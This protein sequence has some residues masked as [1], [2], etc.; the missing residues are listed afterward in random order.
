M[1]NTEKAQSV[2]AN[3]K[4]AK[5]LKAEISRMVQEQMAKEDKM[6]QAY[7]DAIKEAK[8]AAKIAYADISR[9][10]DELDSIYGGMYNT[11]ES[12][13]ER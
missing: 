2:I 8:A 12:E 9:K 3:T 11:D 7:I 6:K 5:I 1:Q 4:K 10:E 13:C